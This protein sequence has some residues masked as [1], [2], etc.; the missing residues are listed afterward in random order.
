MLTLLDELERK[1]PESDL[2][3]TLHSSELMP[4]GSPSFPDEASIETLYREMERVFSRAES[5]GYRGV[6]MREYHSMKK[7]ER[8]SHVQG[9]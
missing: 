4:G 6:T 3:F 7:R 8:E 1:E 5:A 2:L 9:R